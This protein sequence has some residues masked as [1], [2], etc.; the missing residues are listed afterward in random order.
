M[1]DTP[2][3]GSWLFYLWGHSYEFEADENWNVIEEFAAYTGN[4]DEIWYNESGII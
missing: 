2:K 4:R 3:Y 1:E